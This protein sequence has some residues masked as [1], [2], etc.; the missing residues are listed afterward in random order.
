VEDLKSG[1][2]FINPIKSSKMA[3]PNFVSLKK[4]D[5]QTLKSIIRTGEPVYQIAKRM[6][7]QYNRTT[8]SFM[9]TLYKL[10]KQTRKIAEWTGPKRIRKSAPATKVYETSPTTTKYAKVERFEDHIRIYF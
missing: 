2:L 9:V 10:A 7:P 3:R 8:E 4:Q 5:I 1:K 6:A